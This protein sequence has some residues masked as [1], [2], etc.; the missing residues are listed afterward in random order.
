MEFFTNVMTQILGSS[1]FAAFAGASD[2]TGAWWDWRN[3][4]MIL[5]DNAYFK[6]QSAK[7]GSGIVFRFAGN[8]RN[9]FRFCRLAS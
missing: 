9:I 8:R 4:V 1:G 5:V 7:R 6:A 2:A 3:A